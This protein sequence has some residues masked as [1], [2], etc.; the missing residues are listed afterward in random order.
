M[1]GAS[2]A[3]V[4]AS[5]MTKLAHSTCLRDFDGMCCLVVGQNFWWSPS[6]DEKPTTWR[7]PLLALECYSLQDALLA[8]TPGHPDHGKFLIYTFGFARPTIAAK[9]SL[10]RTGA[11][12]GRDPCLFRRSKWSDGVLQKKDTFRFN[13]NSFLTLL[14]SFKIVVAVVDHFLQDWL[15]TQ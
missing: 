2:M 12:S 1:S 8:T 9:S 15:E 3:S 14:L 13:K 10:T 5:W 11:L 6:L 4:R 7:E